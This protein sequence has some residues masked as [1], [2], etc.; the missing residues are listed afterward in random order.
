MTRDDARAYFKETCMDW[1]TLE[2]ED[3]SRLILHIRVYI[4]D[5]PKNKYF[6]I[7]DDE[8]EF[9]KGQFCRITMS[10]LYYGKRQLVTF[11]DE[12]IGIAE[13]DDSGLIGAIL[14]AFCDW[15][16]ETADCRLY[17][18]KVSLW[19]LANRSE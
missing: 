13:G 5:H 9:E 7:P 16:K 12:L 4:I 3:F 1:K 15:C 18:K 6:I 17:K 10:S 11:C 8:L 19:S 14:R 2:K